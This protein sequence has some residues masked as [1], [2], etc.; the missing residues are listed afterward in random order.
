M[1]S[2][3]FLFSC[4][5]EEY[6]RR[7]YNITED[8]MH[9]LQHDQTGCINVNHKLPGLSEKTGDSRI[10]IKIIAVIIGLHPTATLV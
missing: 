9:S 10:L 4:P 3:L 8:K 1:N 2:A 6:S 7:E 5:N